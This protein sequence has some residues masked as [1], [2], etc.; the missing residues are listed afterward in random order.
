MSQ[1]LATATLDGRPVEIVAGFHRRLRDCFPQVRDERND[2]L[3]TSL[4]KPLLYWTEIATLRTKVA[5]LGHRQPAE[6][7]DEVEGDG[8]DARATASS[9]TSYTDHRSP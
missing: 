6:L 7:V 9:A 3:H 4:Q 1:H 5:D 8:F 2:V